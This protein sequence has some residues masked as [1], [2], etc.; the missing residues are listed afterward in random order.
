MKT[1]TCIIAS[2]S[3][4]TH[5]EIYQCTNGEYR[6]T[7]C[8]E[9]PS[10]TLTNINPQYKTDNLIKE[11]KQLTIKPANE[12]DE[13]YI[14]FKASY[15]IILSIRQLGQK[16]T[17]SPDT[18]EYSCR[19]FIIATKPNGDYEKNRMKV[20]GF[21]MSFDNQSAHRGQYVRSKLYDEDIQRFI[22]QLERIMN[23]NNY[24]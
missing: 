17:S 13:K 7:K 18:E 5:A 11:P 10:N 20:D 2:I 21:F 15:D 8:P 23:L 19:I 14:Q 9:G 12:S 3:L 1:L 22:G 6:D 24:R 16:C 4:F